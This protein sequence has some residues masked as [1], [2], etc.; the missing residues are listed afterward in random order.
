MYGIRPRRTGALGEQRVDINRVEAVGAV[1]ELAGDG[2][3]TLFVQHLADLLLAKCP[4]ETRYPPL[5]T[6]A[7]EPHGRRAEEPQIMSREALRQEFLDAVLAQPAGPEPLDP[8]LRPRPGLL[9][10]AR[11][12]EG[13]MLH[14][15]E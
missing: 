14:T 9:D 11:L 6:A 2:H 13:R 4:Q 7:L 15:R 1:T 12:V 10:P 3:R 8:A 5:A